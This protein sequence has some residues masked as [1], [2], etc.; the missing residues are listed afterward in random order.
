MAFCPNC[1][2]PVEGRFCGKCGAAVNPGASASSSAAG[3][4]AGAAAAG[5]ASYVPPTA[6]SSAGLSKN[7]ASALCYALGL[8]TGILFLVLEPYSRDR[9]IRFHAFQS[10]F[11][12]VGCI[13]VAIGISIISAALPFGLHLMTSLLWMLIWLGS[14]GL[15]I[16][17]LVSAFNG[18]KVVLPVV[19]ELAAKQA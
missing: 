18:K 3:A 13:I 2:A 14:F 1:G 15:W 9:D 5:Q 8:I 10:I 17:L 11:F 16:Y 6:S 4:A 7:A 19:G 12:H